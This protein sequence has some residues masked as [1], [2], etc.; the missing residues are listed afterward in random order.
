MSLV[1]GMEI[2]QVRRG[3]GEVLV[4]LSLPVFMI[5]AWLIVAQRSEQIKSKEKTVEEGVNIYD[6]IKDW[7]FDFKNGSSFKGIIQ[8]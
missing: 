8:Y 3:N 2:L 6:G 7:E 1:I 4:H 5:S